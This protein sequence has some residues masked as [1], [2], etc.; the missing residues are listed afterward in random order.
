ML[1]RSP[2]NSRIYTAI[3]A[4][5]TGRAFTANG[6]A[7]KAARNG[8]L[9]GWVRRHASHS[10]PRSSKHRTVPEPR[11]IN[12]L[13]QKTTR[14]IDSLLSDF[15][16]PESG[17]P[18]LTQAVLHSS[19]AHENRAAIERSR[20]RPYDTLAVEG[21]H[22]LAALRTHQQAL[23]TLDATLHPSMDQ[24]RASAVPGAEVSALAESL[25]ISS[26]LLLG[27]GHS[28][29][30]T[31]SLDSGAAQALVA[32][33]WRL[34]PGQLTSRQPDAIANWLAS[35]DNR[36]DAV[37]VLRDEVLGPL[38]L[39]PEVS[40]DHT[41]PNDDRSHRATWSFGSERK[42]EWIG[43]WASSKAKANQGTAEEVVSVLLRHTEGSLDD[44]TAEE[45]EVIVAVVLAAIDTATLS[46]PTVKQLRAAHSWLAVGPLVAGSCGDRKS[47]V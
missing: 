32:A 22:V 39:Q 14:L 1:F 42:A 11:T 41:G 16:L 15:E 34:R 45:A 12:P 3:V 7:K 20:Q 36:L 30:S 25:E 9:E 29:G 37:T 44:C 33:A 5:S 47:V 43:P 24:A 38:G 27:K 13:P 26:A 21:S 19:W 35:F 2:D 23:S 17:R 40:W 28:G 46:A 6:S 31:S 8:A 10:I 4:D 18:L